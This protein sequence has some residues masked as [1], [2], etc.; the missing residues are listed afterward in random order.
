MKKQIENNHKISDAPEVRLDVWLWAARFFKTR[1]LAKVA[2]DGGKVRV[3]SLACKPA[4]AIHVGDVIKTIRSD[5]LWELRVKLLQTARASPA[6]ALLLY[7]ELPEN[8]A[9]R[10]SVREQNRLNRLGY[11]APAGKPDKRAR[12]KI[13]RFERADDQLG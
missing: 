1:A 6:Q 12:Q 13:T 7:G 10:L 11:S 5:E 2:I 4:K 8:T 3:N 9:L